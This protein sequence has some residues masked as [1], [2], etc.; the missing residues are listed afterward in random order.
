MRS[1]VNNW[2]VSQLFLS[3]TGVYEVE[4]EHDSSKLRCNCDGYGRRN[5]CKHTRFVKERMDRNG[6]VYATHISTRAPVEEANLAVKSPEAFR[7]LLIN[8]GKIEVI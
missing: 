1:K 3:D 5:S 4:I 6:G 7:K 2:Q 8:Y